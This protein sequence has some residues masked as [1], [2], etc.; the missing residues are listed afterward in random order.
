MEE[1]LNEKKSEY[2][3]EV[4]MR[5]HDM[6]PHLRQMTSS[7]RLMLYYLDNTNDIEDLIKLL[8]NSFSQVIMRY[9]VYP[10]L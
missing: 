1:S 4:R 7:E 10:N 2:I 6:R 3:N 5:K 9:R 8:K